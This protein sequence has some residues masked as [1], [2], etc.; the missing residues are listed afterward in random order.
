LERQVRQA[1]VVV[2]GGGPA[3]SAAAFHLAD[4]GVPVTVV[5]A[6]AFPR[7]KVCGEYISPAATY[8]LEAIVP[9]E[10]LLRAGARR[11]EQFV[12]ELQ[13][14]RMEWR[15]PQPAWALS[16]GT[17]DGLLLEKAMQKGAA[18]LQ[19]ASVR[20]VTYLDDLVVVRLTDGRSLD[21]G[22]VIHADGSGRHD[23]M[24]PTRARREMIG[25]KCHLRPP[26]GTIRGVTMRSC[27]G[28]YVGTIEVEGVLCTCALVARQSL[29]ARF[30]GDPDAMLSHLWP[31]FHASWRASEW[32]ASGVPRSGYIR[33]GHARSL[34]IGNAAAAVDPV[35]GE[36]IGLALWSGTHAARQIAAAVAKDGVLQAKAI[37]E[38]QRLL[39]RAYR[40]RLRYRLPAC[41]LAAGALVRPRLLGALWPLMRLPSIGIGPWYRLSGKPAV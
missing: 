15:T 26:Q 3:G 36:G 35:G 23:P 19:P 9:A 34:R 30:G 14:R 18:A 17:L 11:V 7:V 21:A 6:R 13:G 31:S 24:G 5:E 8:L 22:L 10:E 32:V 41:G 1:G 2:I 39:A 20:G 16:R 28:A 27:P 25:H 12:V 37:L 29:L 4:A 40:E 33:P 38:I